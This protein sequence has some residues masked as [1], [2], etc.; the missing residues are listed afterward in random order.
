MAHHRHSPRQWIPGRLDDL[1][2]PNYRK[3]GAYFQNG[4]VTELDIQG[5]KEADKLADQGVAGHA[6]ISRL[7]VRAAKRKEV[8]R[9]VQNMMVDI[10]NAHKKEDEIKDPEG[11]VAMSSVYPIETGQY[12]DYDYDPLAHYDDFPSTLPGIPTN[13]APR[14]CLEERFPAYPYDSTQEDRDC[15]LKV[16]LPDA[17]T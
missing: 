10:R 17:P 4:I 2:H 12:D 16:I 14:T 15:K 7:L 6:D 13:N 1:E 9:L 11:I 5:N 8:T 3:R